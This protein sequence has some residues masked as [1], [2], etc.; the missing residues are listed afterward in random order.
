MMRKRIKNIILFVFI[1]F[2]IGEATVRVFHLTV[3]VPKAYKDEN[4]L[5]RYYPNQTGYSVDR[6]KWV[7]NKYGNFGYEPRSLDSMVTIIGSSY[8]SGTM[9]PLECHQAYCLASLDQDYNFF[10]MSRDGA[11]FMEF[12]EMAKCLEEYSPRKQLLYV[13]NSDFIVSVSERVAQP[14]TVQLSIET[15]E[16]TFPELGGSS[17]KRKL[18]QFKFAYYLYRNYAVPYMADLHMVGGRGDESLFEVK[19]SDYPYLQGLFDFVKTHYTIDNLVLVFFPDSDP[20]LVSM[21]EEA[22]FTAL[23]LEAEDYSSW[24]RSEHGHWT[25]YGHQEVARQVDEYLVSTSL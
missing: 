14:S 10:P 24:L 4:N 25:C 9:N 8:I 20:K 16:I 19:E 3:D 13:N 5:F 2:L 15:N 23:L 18:Y 17:L 6:C 11:S 12:M 22:G 7:I 1:G 21:A